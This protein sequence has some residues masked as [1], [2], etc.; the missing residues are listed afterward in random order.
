MLK[1]TV[2]FYMVQQLTL[3]SKNLSHFVTTNLLIPLGLSKTPVFTKKVITDKVVATITDKLNNLELAGNLWL[4]AARKRMYVLT[5][6]NSLFLLLALAL[7]HSQHLLL[8]S[9][10]LLLWGL[11]FYM[12]YRLAATIFNLIKN[13]NN[14]N[15]RYLKIFLVNKGFLLNHRKYAARLVFNRYYHDKLSK[16]LRISH[17]VLAKSGKLPSKNE[18][19]NYCYYYASVYLHKFKRSAT[20]YFVI[21]LA[22]YSVGI[23]IYRIII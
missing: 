18:I 4:A 5:A 2:I 19:F 22:S 17:R 8:L 15:S 12:L 21:P 1:N 10:S 6:I 14:E 3:L 11:I 20:L 16:R 7:Q 23:V 13:K 9:A